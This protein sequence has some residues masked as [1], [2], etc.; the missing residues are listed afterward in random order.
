M[1]LIKTAVFAAVILAF[2]CASGPVEIPNELTPME[3]IQRAQ[4]ASDR[5]RYSISLQY[6]EAILERFPYDIENVCAAEYE[7][8]FIH[9]KQRNY[10]AARDGFNDLLAR[11]DNPDGE[12][13][14][15]RFRILSNIVLARIDE[16]EGGSRTSS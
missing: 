11:Y 4:E 2:S 3:M 5:N 15:A 9:Y 6:Y 16:I 13:L 8:A 14:P 7:I 12:L 10:E 1:K